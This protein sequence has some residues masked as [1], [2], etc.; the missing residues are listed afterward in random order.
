M[1]LTHSRVSPLGLADPRMLGGYRLIGRVGVGGMGVVY[2]AVDRAGRQVAIKLLHAVLADDDEFRRRFRHE[3]RRARQ[4]PPFCT[5]E[6]LDADVDHDPP[7]LVV[8]YIDGPSLDEVVRQHGPL[9]PA[10][11]HSLAIGVAT[12]LTAIHGAGVI[13]RDLKPS[14]VLL[15]PGSPKVIDFG[16]AQ[17]DRP[18]SALTGPDHLAGTIAY[19]A[20][21]RF[22]TGP[23]TA[24]ADIFSWGLVIAFAGTGR[25]PF[26]ADS[27]SST[28]GRILT[29]RPDL[30]GLPEPLRHL[31]ETALSKDPAARPDARDL[32]DLLLATEPRPAT[33]RPARPAHSRLARPSARRRAGVLAAALLLG[34]L[35]TA[36]GFRTAG[37]TFAAD[38]V[39]PSPDRP[40][41]SAPPPSAPIEPTGGV[42]LISDPLSRS[43]Q[44]IYTNI[45]AEHATCTISGTLRATRTDRG[46]LLCIGPE[47]HIKGDHSVSVDTTLESPGSC[48]AIWFF[49]T[50]GHGGYVLR[51]CRDVV[52][53]AADRNRDRRVLGELPLSTPIALRQPLHVQVNAH[54]ERAEVFLDHTYLGKIVLP[55]ADPKDGGAVLGLSVDSVNDNPPF[56]VTYANIDIRTYQR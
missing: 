29:Q 17:T 16:I 26:E 2:A 10:N 12:A 27:P 8:E 11:L 41:S 7:Y 54:T 47:M 22:D 1:A 34:G 42:P 30:S 5:A 52:T 39:T 50:G 19:M 20:P 13:H 45:E 21:E 48:A 18:G 46:V 43:G 38:A 32:L 3:V 35:A 24:A 23:V 31:V 9:N 36:V 55:T 44:W 6:V 15:A 25:T 14:N 53:L 33:H 4:V 51:V 56:A 28:A 49:W 37:G 40:A